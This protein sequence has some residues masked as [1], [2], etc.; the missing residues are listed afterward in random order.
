MSQETRDNL[1]LGLDAHL[2][3]FV[4]QYAKDYLHEEISLGGMKHG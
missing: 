3:A 4:E 1:D 2:K